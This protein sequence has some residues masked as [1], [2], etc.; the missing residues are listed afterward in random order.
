MQIIQVMMTIQIH[1]LRIQNKTRNNPITVTIQYSTGDPTNK[2]KARTNRNKDYKIRK[3]LLQWIKKQQLSAAY[4]RQL[5][6]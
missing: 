6:K 4:K 1:I 3:R 5:Y 2:N